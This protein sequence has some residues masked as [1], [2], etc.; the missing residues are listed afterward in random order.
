MLSRSPHDPDGV[1]PVVIFVELGGADAAERLSRLAE[2][3]EP[4]PHYRHARL[5]ESLDQ[6]LCL[7]VSAWDEVPDLAQEGL[8]PPEARLWRFRSAPHT[9]R[10]APGDS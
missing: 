6:P 2:R 5:L 10:S 1:D 9:T 7:L 3:L 8:L 4:L